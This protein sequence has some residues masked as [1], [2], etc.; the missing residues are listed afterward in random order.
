VQQENTYQRIVQHV[1]I[2]HVDIIVQDE[3]GVRVQQVISERMRVHHENIV[4]HEQVVVVVVQNE[5]MQHQINVVV[6]MILQE[7]SL[8]GLEIGVV[9]VDI[10]IIEVIV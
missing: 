2:V 10:M 8:I 1:V 4:Q 5:S 9:I 7:Q 3:H 6:K